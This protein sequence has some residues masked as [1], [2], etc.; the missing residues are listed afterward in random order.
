MKISVQ[1]RGFWW[2]NGCMPNVLWIATSRRTGRVT[3][4]DDIM[5]SY[6]MNLKFLLGMIRMSVLECNSAQHLKVRVMKKICVCVCVY[7]VH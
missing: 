4:D 2:M 7:Y 6:V 1:E 5:R 3:V